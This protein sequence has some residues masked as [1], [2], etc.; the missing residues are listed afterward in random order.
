M[1]KKEMNVS[2]RVRMAKRRAETVVNL[3]MEMGAFMLRQV[4]EYF[5]KKGGGR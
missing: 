5:E 4:D 1:E 3:P 2:V